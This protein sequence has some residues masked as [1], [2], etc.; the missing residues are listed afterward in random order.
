MSKK[1]FIELADVL[2]FQ[3]PIQSVSTEDSYVH[4][5]E[6]G[7]AI[8]WDHM[9]QHLADFCQ[10][11]NGQFKRDRWLQYINGECGPNGGKL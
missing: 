7:K 5:L 11:Q 9:V 8:M 4:G 10:S 2:R 6:D 3:K 1:H